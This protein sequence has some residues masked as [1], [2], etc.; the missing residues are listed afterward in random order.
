MTA[1]WCTCG[2]RSSRQDGWVAPPEGAS[3]AWLHATCGR[4]SRAN[5]ERVSGHQPPIK[6]PE[7]SRL[8]AELTVDLDNWEADSEEDDWNE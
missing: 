1:P 6:V 4:P 8:P 5:Y 2:T 3:G 7:A